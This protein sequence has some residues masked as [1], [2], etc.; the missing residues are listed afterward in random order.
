MTGEWRKIGLTAL[1]VAAISL[2]AGAPSR[3]LD[4]KDFLGSWCSQTAKL[5]FTREHMGVKWFSDGKSAELKITKFEFHDDSVEVY[6]IDFEKNEVSAVY[7]EFSSDGRIMYL[8]KNSQA[9]HRQ[10]KRC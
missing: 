8:Q 5:T 4:Y 3:A 9:P 6:W 7:S 2:S 1:M 10:Y